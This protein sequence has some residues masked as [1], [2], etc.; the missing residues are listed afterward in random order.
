MINR[1][2]FLAELGKLLTF[3]FDEDRQTALSMYEEMFQQTDDEEGLLKLLVSPTRQ[4]VILARSYNAKERD[5]T[6]RSRTGEGD[7]DVD[8]S[9]APEFVLAIRKIAAKAAKTLPQTEYRSAW[10]NRRTETDSGADAAEKTE[11]TADGKDDGEYSFDK[12]ALKEITLHKEDDPAE[13]EETEKSWGDFFMES[14]TAE[15]R[16][17]AVPADAPADKVTAEN[18]AGR[19]APEPDEEREEMKI[20]LLILYILL[21]VPVTAIG[22]LLL[23][24]PAVLFLGL[25]FALI[26]FGVQTVTAAFGGFAVFADIMIVLG[27]ALVV[28]S[29]GVFALWVFLW[30]IGT[31][32]VNLINGAICLGEK[33]CIS[34]GEQ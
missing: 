29:V 34:G 15:N 17:D 5:L 8:S 4:A 3:M 13:A 27:G 2:K 9:R 14:F 22:V 23:L 11:Q 6:V 32:I 20:G 33:F 31:A 21:A 30:F 18:G 25:A 19:K 12:E 26:S 16:S 1:K 28:L 7:A 24:I 10:G